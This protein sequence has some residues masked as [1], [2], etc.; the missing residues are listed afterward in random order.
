MTCDEIFRRLLE[1]LLTTL[2]TITSPYST[3]TNR[4]ST[5]YQSREEAYRTPSFNS[6]PSPNRTRKP[7]EVE[8]NYDP[9]VSF[10]GPGFYGNRTACGLAYTKTI[11]GVAHRSLPCGTLVEFKYRGRSQ[12]VPVIDRGPY[13]TGRTWDLSG[14]LCVL[15][16]HCF[17]GA[18]E[19]RVVGGG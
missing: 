13:I 16:Q 7:T 4:D 17:T 12:T 14:G 10:Y 2:L 8:W 3:G 18:I 19:W 11:I 5:E 1:F 6:S 15:L 9:E